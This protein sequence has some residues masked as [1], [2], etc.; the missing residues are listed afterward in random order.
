MEEDYDKEK[1]DDFL[2]LIQFQLLPWDIFLSQYC[3]HALYGEYNGGNREDN[4]KE[5]DDMGIGVEDN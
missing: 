4:M 2:L 5:K 1:S 3:L